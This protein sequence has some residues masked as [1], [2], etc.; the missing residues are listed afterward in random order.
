MVAPPADQREGKGS[1]PPGCRERPVTLRT[2]IYSCACPY[3]SIH[4]TD[5]SFMSS[6]NQ[7]PL[8]LIIRPQLDKRKCLPDIQF[9]QTRRVRRKSC[10]NDLL[11]KTRFLVQGD[12]GK[13]S[14]QRSN[15]LS[16]ALKRDFAPHKKVFVQAWGMKNDIQTKT[17]WPGTNKSLIF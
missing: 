7:E 12:R 1:W 16:S 9:L 2:Q 11:T 17:T 14:L 5:I 13:Y 15:S 8:T 6:L 4:K 3:S 10:A